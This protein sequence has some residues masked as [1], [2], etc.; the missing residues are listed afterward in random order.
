MYRS[1]NT[2]GKQSQDQSIQE[3]PFLEKYVQDSRGKYIQVVN[4]FELTWF[5]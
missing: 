1:N 4:L 3:D 5:F 2:Y